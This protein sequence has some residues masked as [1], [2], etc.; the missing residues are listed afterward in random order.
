MRKRNGT[1]FD[2]AAKK[3]IEERDQNWVLCHGAPTGRS[4]EAKGLVHPHAWLEK[5]SPAIVHDTNADVT[6]ATPIYYVLG[7]IDPLKIVKYDWSALMGMLAEH[8]HYGPWDE[9]LIELDGALEEIIQNEEPVVVFSM[10]PEDIVDR[11][12]KRRA[13][14]KGL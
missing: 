13:E 2:S 3:M 11:Y 9:M 8:G 6:I 7:N 5:S 1:C 12:M 14:R 4:G 10:K